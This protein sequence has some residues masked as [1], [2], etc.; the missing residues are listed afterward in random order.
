MIECL[1]WDN[2]SHGQILAPSEHLNVLV[3]TVRSNEKLGTSSI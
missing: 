2:Y 3:A 1:I